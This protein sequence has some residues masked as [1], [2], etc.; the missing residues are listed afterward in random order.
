MGFVFSTDI[1]VSDD[2][3]IDPSSDEDSEESDDKLDID[4]ILS[5]SNLILC[6]DEFNPR[7]ADLDNS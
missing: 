3:L 5:K 6:D 2:E 7:D 1:P 4:K